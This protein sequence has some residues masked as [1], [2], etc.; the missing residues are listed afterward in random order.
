M[1]MDQLYSAAPFN[2][3]SQPLL[4]EQLA[5]VLFPRHAL[6]GTMS[7]CTQLAYEDLY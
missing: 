3:G 4:S 1:I 6:P 5:V 2:F 7:C